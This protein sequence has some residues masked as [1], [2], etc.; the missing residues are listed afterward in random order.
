[1]IL[2]YPNPA[3]DQASLSVKTDKA[4]SQAR[5]RIVNTIGKEM[6]NQKL[7]LAKGINNI[8]LPIQSSWPAGIY[9]VQINLNGNISSKELVLKRE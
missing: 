5:L 7:K 4:Y 9:I 2:L 1:D 6:V 3:I 8:N